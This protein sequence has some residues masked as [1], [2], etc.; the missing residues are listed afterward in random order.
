MSQPGGG[1]QFPRAFALPAQSPMFW[2][3]HKDRFLRQLLI[4]DLESRW[5]R[6]VIVYF[7]DCSRLDAQISGSDDQ[8]LLELLSDIDAAQPVDLIL[9]TNGGRTDATEKL[10]SILKNSIED[11]RVVVP[12][13][14]KSNGTLL[15]LAGKSIVMGPGSELGPIDPYIVMPDGQTFYPAQNILD[16]YE[17]R[18]GI[19]AIEREFARDAMA[20]ST[21]VARELLKTG[22]LQ[23]K[24]DHEVEA[25][26]KDLASRQKHHSHGSV[27][28]AQEAIALGLSVDYRDSIDEYWRWVWLLRCLYE[29][30]VAS[31]GWAK[32]FEGSRI[33]NSLSAE[34]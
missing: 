13:R 34:R 16:A 5:K 4:Q 27:I 29:Y 2:A 14:A 22:M 31:R 30:D 6:R 9:E 32:I 15:A 7:C 10:V 19:T 23:G 33:S 1:D 28:D 18:D 3:E 11:L 20:Q 12:R 17:E 26:V 8:Y 25:V 24:A 21:E